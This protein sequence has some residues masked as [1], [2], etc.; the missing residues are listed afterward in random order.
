MHK[1]FFPA[2]VI[3]LGGLMLSV[4]T[5]RAELFV[6]GDFQ[7]DNGGTGNWSLGEAETMND[8]GGGLWNYSLSG[9][10]AENRY[11]F[12]IVDDPTPATPPAW[13]DG[14]VPDNGPGSPNSWFQ[15]DATGAA[16]IMLDRNTYEDGFLPAQDRISVSTDQTA[17][18]NFYATGN[19]MNESGGTADWEPANS[20]FEMQSQGGGLY[21]V[22]VTVSTPGSYQFKATAGSF[23]FQWGTNGR[24]ADSANFDFQT[25]AENQGVTFLLDLS[26]GA[27]SFATDTFLDGDTDGDTVIE[28]EDD[29]GP[30]RDNWLNETFLRSEGNIDNEGDSAGIVDIADF[31]QWKD[32]CTVAGCATASEIAEAFGSLGAAVPEPNSVLLMAVA[33]LGFGARRLRIRN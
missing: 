9:L 5:T 1:R 14:E 16:T 12:K 33:A 24:L 23:D 27:I 4:S 20:M 2:L 30:I 7:Q 8:L 3:A 29:F 6:P 18:S 13:S 15:T 28:F 21:S 10:S 32:A 17:F 11:Q 31:R 25:V 19:W 22:D 26:K